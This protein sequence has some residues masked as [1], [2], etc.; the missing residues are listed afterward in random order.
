M[1]KL[2]QCVY[3][4]V[5]G[6]GWRGLAYVQA[7][8]ATKTTLLLMAHIWEM[9]EPD[10]WKRCDHYTDSNYPSGGSN[11][12]RLSRTHTHTQRQRQACNQGWRAIKCNAFWWTFNDEQSLTR[13]FNKEQKEKSG[14]ERDKEEGRKKKILM[15]FINLFLMCCGGLMGGGGVSGVEPWLCFGSSMIECRGQCVRGTKTTR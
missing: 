13:R 15:L 2:Q 8:D 4:G 14:Q 7:W 9:E 11:G 6:L 10:T 1:S 5:V 12:S 3:E